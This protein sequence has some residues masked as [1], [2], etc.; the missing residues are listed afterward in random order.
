MMLHMSDEERI[1]FDKLKQ[2]KTKQEREEIEKQL[3]VLAKKE[4]EKR[5]HLPFC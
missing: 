3:T 1:L 5:K 4:K 2:A